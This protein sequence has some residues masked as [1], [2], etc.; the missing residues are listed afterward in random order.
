MSL[1]KAARFGRDRDGR[2]PEALALV[3][4]RDAPVAVLGLADVGGRLAGVIPHVAEEKV[5]AH[6]LDLVARGG[7]VEL[8]SQNLHDLHRSTRDFGN[9]HPAGVTVRKEDLDGFRSLVCHVLRAA[10]KVRGDESTFRGTRS[11]QS[12][13]SHVLSSW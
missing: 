9:P 6:P 7:I 11:Y 5:D 13:S 12:S 1:C 2:R 3:A 10:E 4:I 8:L